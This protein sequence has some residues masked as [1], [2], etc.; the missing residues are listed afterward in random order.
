MRA[1]AASR[2]RKT[3]A[4][5]AKA[6]KKAVDEPEAAGPEPV[7]LDG[8]LD[9]LE[10]VVR[11]LEHGELP[12]ERAL[13][14]FEEGV[15]LAREGGQALERLEARVEVLLEDGAHTEPFAPDPADA[16]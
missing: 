13:A 10:G 2:S 5:R 16:D 9:R 1:M 3:T 6:P 7:D 14:R 4:S 8:I 11:E 12:L 15:R